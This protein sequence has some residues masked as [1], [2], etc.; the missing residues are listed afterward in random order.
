MSSNYDIRAKYYSTEFKPLSDETFLKSIISDYPHAKTI[1]EIPCGNGFHTDFLLST[2]KEIILAD[3]EIKMLN[4]VEKKYKKRVKIKL[5]HTTFQELNLNNEIDILII[6][7]EGFQ[8]LTTKKDIYTTLLNIYK[9][10]RINGIVIIDMANFNF[11]TKYDILCSPKY[12]HPS[13]ENNKKYF[14]WE[15]K[16]ENDNIFIRHSRISNRVNIIKFSFY[17]EIISKD[18]QVISKF[19]SCIKLR[20]NTIE[21]LTDILKKMNFEVHKV[22]GDYTFKKYEIY[23]PR[24][25][26]ILKKWK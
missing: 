21:Y 17:Y 15:R 22:Y 5:L 12:W 3:G 7:Q 14:D 4:E 8:F 13:K 16:L 25:I 18:N 10:L 26:L 9:A 1:L 2:Q 24:T 23:D 19:Q 11:E 20:K 6:P